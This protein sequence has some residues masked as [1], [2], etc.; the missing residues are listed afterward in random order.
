MGDSSDAFVQA[1]CRKACA[2]II[3]AQAERQST[4]TTLRQSGRAGTKPR[5]VS[6]ANIHTTESV[7]NTFADIATGFIEKIGRLSTKSAQISGRSSCNLLDVLGALE[8]LSPVT[9]STPRDLARYCMFQEIPFPQE[10]P[11]FPVLPSS[12]K[13]RRELFIPA[14]QDGDAN[15]KEPEKE[16]AYIE[17]WMPSLPSAHTYVSTPVFVKPEDKKRDAAEVNKQRSGVEKSLAILKE[18]RAKVA[19]SGKEE[20]LAAAAV[21]AP[22]NP[23]LQLPKVGN[24]RVFDDDDQAAD[25]R[26]ITEPADPFP[27]DE[28]DSNQPQNTDPAE[29]AANDQKRARVDRILAEAGGGATAMGGQMDIS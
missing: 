6:A 7:A 21:A 3:Y 9:N 16:R 23:Y 22:R 8:S 24:G 17:P 29:A 25:V 13:R 10:V 1:L 5:P 20:I 15:G 4:Q 11:P 14:V 2:Q 27:E 18:S 19:K 26:A 28:L 12:R